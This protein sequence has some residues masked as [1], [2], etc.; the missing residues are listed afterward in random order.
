VVLYG[1]PLDEEPVTVRLLDGALQFH[2]VATFGALEHRRRILHPGLELGL[3]S[4][5]DVDLC[6][7]G[8]H[9]FSG[10]E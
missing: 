9:G 2:A 4:G 3:H 8:D 10:D 5:L 7:F 6:D 1:F